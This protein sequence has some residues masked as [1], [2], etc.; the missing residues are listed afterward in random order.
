MCYVGCFTSRLTRGIVSRKLKRH[1]RIALHSS[2]GRRFLNLMKV[3]SLSCVE[4]VLKV[5]R[6]LTKLRLKLF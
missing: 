2:R 5:K 1:Q 4:C 3:S 6:S